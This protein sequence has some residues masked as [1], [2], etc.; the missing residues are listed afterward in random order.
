MTM[1]LRLAVATGSSIQTWDYQSPSDT[2]FFEP[3]GN[4]SITSVAWNHNGQGE[5]NVWK[6]N[7]HKLTVSLMIPWKKYA[8][9]HHPMSCH[10]MP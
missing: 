7:K 6:L 2:S 10:A 8:V 4:N 3:L 1:E 9:S 5:T